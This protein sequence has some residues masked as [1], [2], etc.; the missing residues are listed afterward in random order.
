MA[1]AEI[2]VPETGRDKH[3]VRIAVVQELYAALERL[4]AP[5]DLLGIVGNWVDAMDDETALQDLR[6]FNRDG[7][8]IEELAG[9][10]E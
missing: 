9:R 4:N 3:S 5:D 6:A 10:F 1:E 8:L 7:T 2:I